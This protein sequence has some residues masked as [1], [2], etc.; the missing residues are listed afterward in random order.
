MNFTWV[1]VFPTLTES[2]GLFQVPG[3]SF[4]CVKL[5]HLPKLCRFGSEMAKRKE[6]SKVSKQFQIC[7]PPANPVLIS[8]EVRQRFIFWVWNCW[9]VSQST[10]LNIR[11]SEFSP[12][13]IT[14]R[15]TMEEVTVLSS[16]KLYLSYLLYKI[17]V[18]LRYSEIGQRRQRR[19]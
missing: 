10:R 2:S 17:N 6:W 18:R 9:W 3:S 11:R 5:G 1:T 16:V 12:S 13:H 14:S 15:V 7:S 8:R 19:K 4:H